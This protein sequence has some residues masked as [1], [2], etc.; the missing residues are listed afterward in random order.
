MDN[1]FDRLLLFTFRMHFVIQVVSVERRNK[2]VQLFHV[3]V[4]D[5][6]GPYFW[7][8]G[9]REGNDGNF[10]INRIDH[11]ANPTILWSEVMS[12]F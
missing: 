4:L 10:A 12:P 6:V 2:A 9:S 11:R 3:K 5:N 1:T 8:S 7:S